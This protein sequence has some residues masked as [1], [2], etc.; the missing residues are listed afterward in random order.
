M[1][2]TKRVY[3]SG[4]RFDCPVCGLLVK[5]DSEHTE[6]LEGGC[7]SC[8]QTIKLV[9][10][11]EDAQLVGKGTKWFRCTAC[12]QLHMFRRGELVLA[13]PRAGFNEFTQF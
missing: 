1:S 13:Q 6:I 12:K 4:V 8:Q 10:V 5:D 7:L 2:T 3:R 9:A 11:G